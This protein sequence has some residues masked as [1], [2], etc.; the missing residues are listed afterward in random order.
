MEPLT[1]SVKILPGL[2]TDPNFDWREKIPEI[3]ALG[4]TEIAL[5][6]TWLEPEERQEM[7][8]TLEQTGLQAIPHVHLRH[9]AYRE[10]I[11]YLRGRFHTRVL[12][13]HAFDVL[14]DFLQDNPDLQAITYVE[15]TR[16]LDER[17]LRALPLCAGIC[18][19]FAHLQDYWVLRHVPEY[20]GFDEHL[21][22]Y[23]IGCCHIG[24][25]RDELWFVDGEMGYESH[26]ME[27][28]SQLEY[29]REHAHLLPDLI[30]IEL[31]NTFAEQQAVV[32]F[33]QRLT[34][35]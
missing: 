16:A 19:D 30:S 31:N 8:A 34:P 35:H 11:D 32:D 21:A 1:V 25:V 5:F 3:D 9:D 27:G 18:L 26:D 4:L 13:I 14:I 17:F 7:Y 6:P 20:E 10:E 28:I 12:N 15:N 29:L 22:R 33:V 2:T 23:P 24:A